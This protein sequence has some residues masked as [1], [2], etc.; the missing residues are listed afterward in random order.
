MTKVLFV[1]LG[2][3]CRSPLAQGIFEHKVAARGLTDFYF[4]D[5]AG[6]SAYHEGEKP[7]SGSLQ[8]ARKRNISIEHQRS[9]PVRTSDRLEFDVFVAMD[10]SN[11]H[12]LEHEFAIPREKLLL[13]RDFDSKGKG[14]DVPDPWGHGPE[15]FAEVFDIL[16]RCCDNLLEFLEKRRATL[17][18]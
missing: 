16:D 6:T 4:A 8:I 17:D 2:N 5:S 15:A 18:K 10:H 13:M 7:H 3:I 1:C 14:G 12:T 9:R 11:Y